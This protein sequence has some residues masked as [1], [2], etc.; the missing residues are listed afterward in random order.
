MKRKIR[1]EFISVII[2]ALLA[3]SI[4]GFFIVKN[5]LKDITALNLNTYLE[6]TEIEYNSNPNPEDIVEKYEDIEDYLRIT[7]MDS[8][9]VIIA[10]SLAENL[11]NH[12]SR[13]E[14]E[15]PGTIYI[16][17]SSTL[18]IEMMYL[19]HELDD[20]NYIRVAVPTSSILPFA[21]DFILLSF[22]I[23]AMII[24]FTFFISRALINNAMYPLKEIKSILKTVNQG[25]YKEIFPLKKQSEINELL[26][27]INSINHLIAKNIASLTSEKEKNDFLLTHMN[28]G[29]CVLDNEGHIVMINQHLRL[30]F[31]FNIDINL[32]KDYRYLFRDNEIQGFIKKAYDKQINTNTI[33]KVS[34]RHYSISINYVEKNWLN[35]P[36]IILFFTDITD[37]KN[38]ENLKKDFFDNASHE[39]KSPLTSIIGSSDIILQGMAKDKKMII[40]LTK[41]IS[42]EAKRMNSLVMDMLTLS[43]YENQMQISNQQNMDVNRVLQEVVFSLKDQANQKFIAIDL[44]NKTTYINA[45]YDEIYQLLKNLIENAIKYGKIHG[46]IKVDLRREDT[47]LAFEVSDDGI[48]I[49]KSEQSRIFERFYRVDKA[50]SKAIGGTGLGLS[51]VKHI[52]LNYNG[53]IELESNENQGTKITVYLPNNEINIQ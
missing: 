31:R 2:F 44:S 30:L 42:E 14:F 41:R 28:Q 11:E 7:I 49:P 8:Y 24:V 21:N 9:G 35:K 29:L 27:E 34:D 33:L 13:P 10:D 22:I 12:L 39:L 17:K 36:S 50:R 38:I 1:I 4:G 40:D 46:H 52:V 47:N 26:T 5:N 43:K 20:G 51:I 3:L 23:G 19:A 48:G 32:H 45:N 37:L 53:H 15:N 25:E 16:R 6:I 18:N